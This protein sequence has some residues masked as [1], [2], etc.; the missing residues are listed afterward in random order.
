M[1]NQRRLFK[2]FYD[3]K[4]KKAALRASG[5]SGISPGQ[6]CH[7]GMNV[8]EEEAPWRGAH[9]GFGFGFKKLQKHW[10]A[11]P[12]GL[13]RER[14][15]Q[16]ASNKHLVVAIAREAGRF[17]NAVLYAW[18]E[19]RLRP[20]R[21]RLAEHRARVLTLHGAYEIVLDEVVG[22]KISTRCHR[23]AGTRSFSSPSGFQPGT[24]VLAGQA[25]SS[26]DRER[27]IEAI[28]V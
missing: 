28:S 23:I 27:L 20:P 10:H 25:C 24:V 21:Q 17:D 4:C 11:F 3:K 18:A 22:L 14:N 7:P 13:L 1:T 12:H 16:S 6:H 9:L 19:Q 8:D 15:V 2:H 26:A 5:S